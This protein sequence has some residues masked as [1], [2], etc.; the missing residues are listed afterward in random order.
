M[1]LILKKMI[2]MG[3]PLLLLGCG[4]VD[5]SGL[6]TPLVLQ[7]SELC[8]DYPDDAI[9][10]FED[11][12]FGQAT[13]EAV[14]RTEEIDF[15]WVP[16]RLTPEHDHLTCGLISGLN[17]WVTDSRHIGCLV[18][19]Q[20]LTGLSYLSLLGNSIT[21]LGP[22]SGLTGRNS[23]TRGDNSITDLSPLSGSYASSVTQRWRS[24]RRT[25]SG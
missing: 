19:G 5:P 14:N 21:E 22:L 2:M 15:F 20:N 24:T 18:G 9:P 12:A 10:T 23:R 17:G 16:V 25:A 3:L 1:A 4:F 8:S 6:D 13:L 7:P 11:A